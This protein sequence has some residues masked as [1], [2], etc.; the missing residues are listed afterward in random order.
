MVAETED[1]FHF[2]VLA[3]ETQYWQPF[4]RYPVW[5]CISK[6]LKAVTV[7]ISLQTSAALCCAG[8]ERTEHETQQQAKAT[9]GGIVGL[10]QTLLKLF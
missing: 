5:A 7:R 1:I 2:E 8:G 9:N 10:L 3:K 4:P 6:H